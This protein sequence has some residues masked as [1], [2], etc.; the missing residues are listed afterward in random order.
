MKKIL[1]SLIFLIGMSVY[2]GDPDGGPLPAPPVENCYP[3]CAI[4]C[5]P[6]TDI[7]F[8]WEDCV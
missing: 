8:E 1:A 5:I 4:M 7:C 3:V 6:F 2:A